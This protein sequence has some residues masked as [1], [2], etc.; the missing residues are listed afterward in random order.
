MDLVT[1]FVV[2]LIGVV[3]S[4]AIYNI[5]LLVVG[6]RKCRREKRHG[7]AGAQRSGEEHVQQQL[8]R[9][10]VVIPARSEERVL[11]RL[12]RAILNQNYPKENLE[13]IVV[14]D[15]STDGT[16]GICKQF[17][18]KNTG[19]MTLVHGDESRGKPSALN[20]G[21]KAAQGDIIAVFDADNVPEEDA[22][23]NA[24]EYFQ[25]ASVAALQGRMLTVNS[26]VN[27]LTK[28]VSYEE[29]AWCEA[30]LRG[31]DALDLF[32]HLRG[33]CEFVRREVLERVGGW[34]EDY[35]SDDFE[36]SARLTEQG[37]RI[38]YAPDVRSWQES[39]QSLRGMFH[40]RARWFRGA[41]EVAMS[42]GRLMRKPSRKTLD[43]EVTLLAPFV[44][45]LSLLSYL[46][47]PFTIANLGG[48]I[49]LVI[50]VIGWALLTVTIFAGAVALL[51]VA[52]PKKLSDLLWA[53][54]I[55]AYWV[56]QVFLAMWALV[57]ILCRKP[58]QWKKTPRH[59]TVTLTDRSS[60]LQSEENG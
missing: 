28:F 46:L 43:A 21:L 11:P 4:W 41:M 10:S 54:F 40:Q 31:R 50:S 13:V 57:R 39:P 47:C 51:Y 9:F 36:L 44:L 33:S 27:M 30:Y 45:I 22:L 38:K 24:A 8:P 20:R 1:V 29:A 53:P 48:S 16:V 25:D 35:L 15:G 26:E 52:R 18:K 12:F 59:G 14:E 49:L 3:Y 32:V 60:H 17:I 55:Y 56:F 58:Q 23:W 19:L 37:Y 2:M 5:P 42:Y 7:E 34:R 6:V